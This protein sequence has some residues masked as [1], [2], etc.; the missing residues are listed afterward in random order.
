MT[1]PLLSLLLLSEPGLAASSVTSLSCRSLI[2][3][4]LVIL[5]FVVLGAMVWSRP[6]PVHNR[7]FRTR[8]GS[9]ATL[10]NVL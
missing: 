1:L 5:Y 2:A 8:G 9:R 4:A 3:R 7:S 10:M 6:P